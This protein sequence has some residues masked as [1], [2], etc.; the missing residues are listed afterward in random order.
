MIPLVL[1]SA[2]QAVDAALDRIGAGTSYVRLQFDSPDIPQPMIRENLYYSDS[3]IAVWSLTDL[4]DGLE[5]LANNSLQDIVLSGISIEIEVWQARQT[6]SIEQAVPRV[7]TVV[8]GDSLEVEVTIR[9]YRQEPE[10]RIMRI[11][12][13]ED[14]MPDPY[15]YGAERCA[16]IM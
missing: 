5:L 3:D 16:V 11:D 13:P 15:R 6:A 7:S 8:P 12:I 9:P 1:S 14:T 4:M 2:Y 10:K